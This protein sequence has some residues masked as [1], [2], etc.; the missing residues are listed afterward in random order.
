[1]IETQTYSSAVR[2]G[3]DEWTDRCYQVHYLPASRY[4]GVDNNEQTCSPQLS[5]SVYLP[6]L[7]G[8]SQNHCQKRANMRVY[9]TFSELA[10]TNPPND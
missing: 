3:T 10:W 9:N 4:Y 7:A 1:M 2:G 6:G 8:C 5:D